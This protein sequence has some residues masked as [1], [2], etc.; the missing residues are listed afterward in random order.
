MKLSKLEARL[1]GEGFV[2]ARMAAEKLACSIMTVHRLVYDG[3]IKEVDWR[4]VGKAKFIRLETLITYVEGTAAR[5]FV[6]IRDWSEFGTQL[7]PTSKRPGKR[8]AR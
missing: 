4:L 5:E 6:D 3:K 7:E 2:S 8:K 1:F